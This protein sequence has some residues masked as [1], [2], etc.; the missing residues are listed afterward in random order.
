LTNWTTKPLWQEFNPDHALVIMAYQEIR[1][2]K[3]YLGAI[4]VLWYDLVAYYW[5]AGYTKEGKKLF[6]P[7][8]LVWEALKLS[9][10][11]G[12]TVFDFE[13]IY[14]ERLPR[15]GRD[16]QGFTKFKRGFGGKEF[17]Y[18]LPYYIYFPKV[19]DVDKH[20]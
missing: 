1:H 16:W 17:L 3:N 10:K 20:H 19:L 5:M 11:K 8:L 9:K 4:L 2:T 14:D 6:A 13:G 18:P 12:N 7:S 15:H